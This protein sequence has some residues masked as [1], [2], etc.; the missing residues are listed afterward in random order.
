MEE[1]FPTHILAKHQDS[2]IERL[3]FMVK[4]CE[5]SPEGYGNNSALMLEIGGREGDAEGDGEGGIGYVANQNKI[6]YKIQRILILAGL[7]SAY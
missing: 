3:L 4:I 7:N 6:E 2:L 5:F 1:R